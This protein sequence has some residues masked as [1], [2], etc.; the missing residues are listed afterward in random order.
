[1][2]KTWLIAIIVLALALI[3]TKVSL[4][5]QANESQ[6]IGGDR[7]EHGCIGSAGYTWNESLQKC[8]RVFEEKLKTYCE[9]N[10]RTAE[11]CTMIYAPVCGNAFELDD[12]KKTYSNPCAACMNSQIE[13]YIQ[14]ECE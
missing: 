11:V 12:T 8:V 9:E 10:Q 2:E 14:G 7:D 4:F 13:Y 6:L 3:V 1:M 5:N